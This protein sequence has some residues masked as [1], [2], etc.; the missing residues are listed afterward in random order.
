MTERPRCGVCQ[1]L[2]YDSSDDQARSASCLLCGRV[3]YP[4]EPVLPH[5]RPPV[6]PPGR[7]PKVRSA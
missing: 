2:L 7:R 3:W 6:P 5:G 4:P 1:G